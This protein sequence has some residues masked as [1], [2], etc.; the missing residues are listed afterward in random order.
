[1]ATSTW[2]QFGA[3]LELVE[4]IVIAGMYRAAM[5]NADRQ[6]RVL[7]V[8]CGWGRYGVLIKDSWPWAYIVGVDA[9]DR[10]MWRDA[11]DELH[12]AVLP[13]GTLRDL[14]EF[15]VVLLLDVIEHLDKDD[16]P[17]ALAWCR[18]HGPTIL[19]TPNGLMEQDGGAYDE[20]RSGWTVDDLHALG[21]TR[22]TVVPSRS[23]HPAADGP[24]QIVCLFDQEAA[25]CR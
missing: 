13:D 25:P 19:S 21:A 23:R 22:L 20:H 2:R 16:G 6:L 15:E 12:G 7:D 8:G 10:V 5:R 3:V 14:G 18:A 24:G 17:A 9:L 11:Y 1:M 4:D